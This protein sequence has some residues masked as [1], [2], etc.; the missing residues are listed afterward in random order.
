MRVAVNYNRTAQLFIVLLAI[1]SLPALA[2]YY[3]YLGDNGRV[4]VAD[5][6]N[7]E[8]IR[9]GYERLNNSGQVVEV[10]DRAMTREESTKLNADKIEAQRLQQ[11]DEALLLKY[12]TIA[13]IEAAELRALRDI[14]VRLGILKSNQSVL[15]TQL[16]N[17][18]AK[19]A[20]L[21]RNH[22]EVPADLQLRIK[23]LALELDVVRSTIAM[24]REEKVTT[25]EDF[26]RDIGRFEVL[27]TIA[28]SRNLYYTPN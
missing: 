18:Q 2:D 4:V 19:A 8:A 16:S 12:S 22:R 1:N 9:R 24:R 7:V 14:D 25:S 6:L 27:K 21:E 23:N 17:E 15:K 28:E 20:N 5:Q 13:D 11:W 3:R 10:V 26:Q